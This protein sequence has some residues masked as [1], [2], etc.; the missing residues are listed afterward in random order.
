MRNENWLSA[1][2][3]SKKI[4]RHLERYCAYWHQATP[5]GINRRGVR[6]D[7]VTKAGEE[8][9]PEIRPNKTPS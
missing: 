9:W 1:N 6:Q 5:K 3:A 4:R 2:A 8:V 7:G